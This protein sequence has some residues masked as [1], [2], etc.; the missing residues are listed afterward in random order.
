MEFQIIFFCI[1]Y[2]QNYIS[3]WNFKK[4][5]YF[6]EIQKSILIKFKLNFFVES[7]SF[8]DSNEI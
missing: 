3:K 5:I 8:Y 1:N 2:V 7:N 6:N 4:N